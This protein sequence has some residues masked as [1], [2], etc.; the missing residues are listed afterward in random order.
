[1]AT[2]DFDVAAEVV[3]VAVCLIDGR[4]R[5]IEPGDGTLRERYRAV[6]AGAA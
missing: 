4:L 6:V 2:H 3:D 1:M 5:T